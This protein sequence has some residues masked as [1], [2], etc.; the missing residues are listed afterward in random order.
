VCGGGRR[1]GY[2]GGPHIPCSPKLPPSLSPFLSPLEAGSGFDA[3]G[4]CCLPPVGR[5]IRPLENHSQ[6]EAENDFGWG[7]CPLA[8]F[9]CP[10]PIGPPPWPIIGEAP[11]RGFSRAELRPGTTIDARGGP[12]RDLPPAFP[13]LLT[14]HFHRHTFCGRRQNRGVLLREGFFLPGGQPELTSTWH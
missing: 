13:S 5:G 1:G 2:G 6:P 11:T 8:S 3:D 10:P 14:P 7:K 12:H 9:C 4:S